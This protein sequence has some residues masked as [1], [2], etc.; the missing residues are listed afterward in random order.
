MSKKILLGVLAALIVST[1]VVKA[2]EIEEEVE[3][4]VEAGAT[5]ALTNVL[6]GAALAA[7]C[8]FQRRGLTKNAAKAGEVLAMCANAPHRTVNHF[9][10]DVVTKMKS[11]R[12]GGEYIKDFQAA[13]QAYAEAHDLD[14]GETY[15]TIVTKHLRGAP[16][17]AK[18]LSDEEDTDE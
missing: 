18:T 12:T 3:D 14:P 2:A 8:Q 15:E 11:R 4:E 7:K 1:L 5:H 9:S 10:Q 6:S 13:V 17:A 16:P